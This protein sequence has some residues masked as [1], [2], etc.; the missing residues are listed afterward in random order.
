MGALTAGYRCR[1]AEIREATPDDLDAVFDLLTARDRA[2][3]GVSE[4]RRTDLEVAWS[5]P[6]TDRWV[7][8]D[9]GGVV[10][11]ATL[12]SAHDFAPAVL[13]DATAD[14]LLTCAAER[15]RERGFDHLSLVT[16]PKDEVRHA[17]AE[18]AGFGLD[19]QILR[20][21]RSLNG[22]LPEPRWPDGVTVRTYL[23]GDARAV[24]SLLDRS[25]SGWDRDYV[26]RPP[27]DWVAFMTGHAEF[28]PELWF[29]VERDSQ[30][31]ACALH[32]KEH[33][34]RGWVKDIVVAEPERG[35][36]LAKAMLH[37]AFHA[38]QRRGAEQ[39]GLKVD[40]SN[41]TGALQLYA[42][43]GFD[44]DQTLEI[45]IKRL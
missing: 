21:W 6:G 39:V 1:V 41:P 22:D 42:R 30:L 20:M 24:Q 32:W 8:V 36:G 43:E 33:Q 9:D 10:G 27:E 12:T 40:S 16:D 3:F 38:Y 34:S 29:L 37:H 25:Y 17:L 15:A 14:A 44:T 31:I 28:D 19:R 4:T 7:A 11:H 2:V 35:R 26:A 18:R 13:A 23:P 5:V 45:W